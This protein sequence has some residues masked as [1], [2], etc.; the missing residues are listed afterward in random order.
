MLS[1]LEK[2]QGEV[3]QLDDPSVVVLMYSLSKGIADLSGDSKERLLE[4]SRSVVRGFL[5][6]LGSRISELQPI[7]L[8]HVSYCMRR[9]NLV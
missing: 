3:P 9:L 7:N 5:Q 6:H 2:R 8:A 1:G 4:R